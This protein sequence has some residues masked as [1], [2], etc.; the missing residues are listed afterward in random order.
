[1][2]ALCG[3]KITETDLKN[4]K[5]RGADPADLAGSITE[6]SEDDRRFLVSWF[7]FHGIVPNAVDIVRRLCA[8]GSAAELDLDGLL[9][10]A[11]P[12]PVEQAA[13]S[14]RKTVEPAQVVVF[15][16]YTQ[17]PEIAIGAN[18]WGFLQCE[19]AG[20]AQTTPRLCINHL[21]GPVKFARKCEVSFA[22]IWPI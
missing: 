12:D 9:E 6:L 13:E 21:A 5:R 2:T 3:V 22:H 20:L 7:S 10:E 14:G 16:K 1:M 19:I 18:F 11:R 17:M 8:P 4:A 15:E